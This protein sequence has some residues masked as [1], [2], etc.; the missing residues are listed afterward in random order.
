MSDF[1]KIIGSLVILFTLSHYIDNYVKKNNLQKSL[2][3]PMINIKEKEIK[4]K[5]NDAKTDLADVETK[6]KEEVNTQINK[7]VDDELKK[8]EQTGVM[9][10]QLV[11]IMSDKMKTMTMG[12]D[13]YDSNYFSLDSKDTQIKYN[14]LPKFVDMTSKQYT[15]KP[16]PKQPPR[17]Q[18]S[19]NID[20]INFYNPCCNDKFGSVEPNM[21]H[22]DYAPF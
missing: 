13:E 1:E 8:T 11:N 19:Y 22:S 10:P 7:F 3:E 9:S 12:Y 6:L 5:I 14:D 20:G 2:I 21:I 18:K 4:Q 17:P 16:K 15:P